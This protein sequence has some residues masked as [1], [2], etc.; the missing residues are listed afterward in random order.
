MS[1]DWPQHFPPRG[2]VPDAEVYDQFISASTLQWWYVNAHL[3]VKGEDNSS[4]AFFASFFR[5][6]GDN[7]PTAATKYYDACVWALID[8]KNKKC[9]A[10]SALDPESIDQL[11]LRLDPA[12]MGRKLEH[13]EVALLELLNK[14][15]VP[16]P[17]RLLKRKAVYTQHP[18]SIAL[19]DSCVMTIAQEGSARRYTFS[20]TNAADDVHVEVCLETQQ[21]PVLHG[22]DGCV[23]GMYYYYF[24]SM[25]VTGYVVVK[26]LKREVTGLGWYDREVG[27]ST[28]EVDREAKYTWSWLSLH[29][30]NMSQLSIFYI[31]GNAEDE[32]KERVIVETRAD[33][34]RHYHD[35]LIME[36][37]KSWSSLV[38]FMQYPSEFRLCSAS[39][40]LD[41]TIHTAFD[42]QE[43][44]TVLVGGA[45]FYEGV[46]EG[47]G[48]CS[49]DAVTLRGFFEYKKNAAPYR[50]TSELLKYVGSYVHGALEEIYPLAASDSWLSENV[51]GR[52]AMDRGAPAD[53][54][55]ETLFRPVR[56]IIDR[57]GKSWRSLILVSCCNA[58]SR[59]YFD[60]R[61][62]IAVA[63]LLHVGSLIIDDIQ[64]NSV[65]RRGGKC[66]H[67]EY[68]VATAINAGS[69]CYF[70]GPRAARIQD[71]PPEKASR[72]YQL[73]FDVLLAGHAGQGLDIYRLDY[74]MP[75]VVETGDASTL[76]DALD[77]IHT[78]KT[79]GAVGALCSM[80]CVLCEAPTVLSEAVERF[81]LA[82][83]L[84]FQ[85]VDDALNIRGFEENLKE[86]AEDIK[87]G[88]IT[89][90]TAIAMGRLEAADRQTLWAILRKPTK[91]AA[92]IQQ[93]V[94]LIMKVDAT[95]ECFLIA[96]HRLQEMW[97]ALDPLLEDSFPK[98]LMR[99]FCS[100]LVE[101]K[102]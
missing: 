89:Y 98:L 77:A 76:F 17:D 8:L 45:G 67:V 88:K 56:S 29:A 26:G 10:E 52:Y 18:F 101:R 24:P 30:S 33:G 80:A 34:S 19:D 12:V 31:S 4:L 6:A 71:L 85:I 84:A 90:P 60:C 38:T 22:K 28:A 20:L 81:G 74:L 102:Y 66:V 68:G 5:Q 3:T 58:L 35:D 64:D 27:G 16:R 13:V 2:T 69:A 51:L 57:G 73:Y 50:N 40:G 53:K 92:D 48:V 1:E 43:I 49:G 36:T 79:G 94:E 7:C 91:E 95:S 39:M 100:F 82:L 72:I 25:S 42:A 37:N 32:G 23:N 86:E 78:Y 83:G 41:V 93:A 15:R 9:Y 75:K 99:T 63:E 70:M 14:G 21:Q 96:R 54:I 87:D 47:S 61:R 97:N 46:V 44:G 62:Y 59:Q 55:C 65:V 11:K